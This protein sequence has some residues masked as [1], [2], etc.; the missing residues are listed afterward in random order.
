MRRAAEDV[1]GGGGCD[2]WR[3]MRRVAAW[4]GAAATWAG[5]DEAHGYEGWLTG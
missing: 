5:Y 1:T 3:G 4:A 2:G